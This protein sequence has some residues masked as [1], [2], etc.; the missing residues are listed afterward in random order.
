MLFSF[1]PI[2][3]SISC[4]N[5]SETGLFSKQNLAKSDRTFPINTGVNFVAK[6]CGNRAFAYTDD[7]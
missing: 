4:N 6:T 1:Q 2:F 5:V 3:W 7:F